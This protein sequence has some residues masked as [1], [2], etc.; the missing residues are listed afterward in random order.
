MDF[1]KV[2][3]KI[4]FNN[5]FVESK[6]AKV[7]VLNHSLHFATSIFEGIGVYNNKPLFLGE[8]INRLFLSA[9]L[10][11][12]KINLT[13]NKILDVC[14][15]LVKI[16]KI[17][18]GYIRPLI[19]RSSHSMSPETSNC[20]SQVAIASW[21]WGKLFKKKFLSLNISKYPK[22]NEKIY[23]TQAK[24]SGSYQI[25]VIERSRIEKTK[26]DDCLM[27]DMN[28]NV[29]ETSACNIFWI[30]KNTVYTPKEHSIL[31]GVTR[32]CI[33][34]LCKDNNIKL[35]I[36]D[37]KIK[38]L[39]SAESV[40]ITGTAAE[41]QMVKNIENKKFQIKSNI[42]EFLKYKYENLKKIGPNFIKYI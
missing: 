38:N 21:K 24:S 17:D 25:S 6:K 9:D 12:L 20:K 34:K 30:K 11:R 41:I 14:N 32:R 35:K 23:P 16:N 42:I 1:S 33:I 29:A 36:N 4:F 27:L 31:N 18:N 28:K 15:K 39:L 13:K 22:L 3:G 37:Y 8:H 19:F 7:H 26:F 40:F 2:N 10:M 5:S